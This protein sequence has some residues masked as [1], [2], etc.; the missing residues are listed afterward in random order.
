MKR[1]VAY[2]WAFPATAIGLLL[3]AFACLGGANGRI[4]D[5]TIE[6]GGGRLRRWVALLPP[7]LRFQAI[8]F[9]HVVVGLDHETLAACRPHERVHVRQY[10][11]WGALFFPLYIGS[12]VVAL[13][14][15]RHPYW[16]NRFERQAYR[17]ERTAA[18]EQPGGY[19]ANS[20][21]I[22]D[23]SRSKSTG[24]TR[25]PSKPAS[26]ERRRSDG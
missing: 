10:E 24:L 15:G 7:S 13:L 4:I 19:E 18:R 16:Y 6:V 11:R 23:C 14:R 25:C 3:V 21:L 22:S 26:A 2:L 5:G 12:S 1:A 8:T 17:E 20:S 9:G